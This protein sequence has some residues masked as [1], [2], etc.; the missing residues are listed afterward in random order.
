MFNDYCKFSENFIEKKFFQL[1]ISKLL[2]LPISHCEIGKKNN[3][4][5]HIVLEKYELKILSE[6]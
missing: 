6:Y 1:K 4:K 3:I 2:S 5:M